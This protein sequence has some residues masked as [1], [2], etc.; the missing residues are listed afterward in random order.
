MNERKQHLLSAVKINASL[1][2]TIQLR[3]TFNAVTVRAF[4][5]WR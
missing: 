3:R 1:V 2:R 4:W 5:R